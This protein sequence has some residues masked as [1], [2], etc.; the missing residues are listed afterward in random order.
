MDIHYKQ[1]Q[2]ELFPGGEGPLSSH[3]RPRILFS[4]ITLSAENIIVLTVIVF[5][6]IILSFSLGVEK[7]KR[8]DLARGTV[9]APVVVE[10][11]KPAAPLKQKE[12]V[13]TSAEVVGTKKDLAAPV[14]KASAQV[15]A[16]KKN[17]YTVQVASFKS[18][19]YAEDEAKGLKGRGYE[20]FI[21]SKGQHVI[22]CAGRF[23][24]QGAA[25]VFLG[26][27]KGKYKDCLVRRL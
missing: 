11:P 23:L 3:P 26:K 18:R 6:G 20:T 24:D 13:K 4:S 19:K 2:F 25:N 12:A 14:V 27:V 17:F 8:L 9:A 16:E 1:D 15:P 21:V 7:G 5:L 10:Q 22:V